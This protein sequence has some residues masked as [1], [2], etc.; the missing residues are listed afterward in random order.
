MNA[1]FGSTVYGLDLSPDGRFLAACGP[2]FAWIA[3]VDDPNQVTDIEGATGHAYDVVFAPD[4][5]SIVVCFHG[6]HVRRY[7]LD[8]RLT[9]RY[10]GHGGVPDGVRKVVFHASGAVLASVGE[11]DTLR[12]WNADTA[13]QIALFEHG[14]DVNTV[15]FGPGDTEITTGSDDDLRI[16]D[17]KTRETRSIQTEPIAEVQ[18]AGGLIF[19]QW[20]SH[21]RV[22]DAKLQVLTELAQTDVS[23]LRVV[24]TTLFAASWRGSHAGVQRWDLETRQRTGLSSTLTPFWALAVDGERV[25][26]G[27]NPDDGR[28]VFVWTHDGTPIDEQ[29][30]PP[31]LFAVVADTDRPLDARLAAVRARLDDGA[32]VNA[33]DAQGC[34]V[35]ACAMSRPPSREVVQLLLDRGADVHR[36]DGQGLGP[37]DHCLHCG[38]RQADEVAATVAVARLLLHAGARPGPASRPY[39]YSH[40]AP[41]LLEVVLDV[42]DDLEAQDSD[43]ESLLH[44][45]ARAGVALPVEL[46]LR[47]GVRTDVV[48][49]QG[50]TPL[51][52][53]WRVIEQ[54]SSRVELARALEAAGAPLQVD[55]PETP[56]FTPF[57]RKAMT[58][59]LEGAEVSDRVRRF[60]A[61]P[62]MKVDYRSYQELTTFMHARVHDVSDT[63]ASIA[64][65]ARA[66]GPS[67]GTLVLDGPVD[68]PFFH[69]GDVHVVVHFEVAVPFVVTGDLRVDGAMVTR[70]H[71]GHVMVGGDATLG[72]LDAD[73]E[74]HVGGLLTVRDLLFARYHGLHRLAAARIVAGLFINDDRCV[75]AEVDARRFDVH[76]DEQWQDSL[77]RLKNRLVPELIGDDGIDPDQLFDRLRAGEP[78]YLEPI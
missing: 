23:R 31:D 50:L 10:I 1:F 63:M 27:S 76:T 77:P 53:A 69:H 64:L 21:I 13:Q 36:A 41:G 60:L 47:K 16:I 17:L 3:P 71:G 35:L 68:Q 54:F 6:G 29:Q 73:C 40:V 75:M 24:G 59:A 44:R 45:L 49:K 34:S 19:T 51:H 70:R 30:P 39:H 26:G 72:A 22:L 32:D 38:A 52:L 33:V 66:L 2:S 55:L 7:D 62:S 43:G 15:A 12:V 25:F 37:L 9:H 56:L 67:K 14:S 18:I 42:F 78:V 65:M 20:G 74:M 4:G 46:L 28:T 58:R 57:E 5:A 61:P 8:G 11:D 48:N